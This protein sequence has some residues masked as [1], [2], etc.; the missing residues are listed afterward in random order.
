MTSADSLNRTGAEFQLRGDE[1]GARVH[2]LAALKLDPAFV[3]ALANLCVILSNRNQLASA[4]VLL[5]RITALAPNDGL[6]M[7][8]LGNILTRLERFDE[9]KSAFDRAVELRPDNPD[10][11]YNLLLWAHRTGDQ[12]A[13]LGY[14][15]RVLELG[16]DTAQVRNDRAHLYLALGDL[17]TALSLYE[18]RWE[19]LIHL[20]PWDLH[21]PEW[22]GFDL[23]GKHI[24]VHG[25]QGF[26][27][28]LMT[29]RFIPALLALGADVTFAV[30][31]N[32][33]RFFEFQNWNIDVVDI[34]KLEE[35]HAG[36]FDCHSPLYGVMRHLGVRRGDIDPRPFLKVPEIVGP[37]V[38]RGNVK[39]VGI[40]WVSGRRGNA[41]DWR[42]RV[43]DL[44]DWLQLADIPGIYLW[45]LCYDPEATKQIIDLG[46]EAIVEDRTSFLG[47][48]AD[49]AAFV[50]QLDL[51]ITVDTAIAHLA[52]GMGKATWMLSQFTPC[53]R[54][55][56][57]ANGTGWP[58]YD[59]MTI[60]PQATPGGWTNQ[61]RQCRI[62]L[63]MAGESGLERAA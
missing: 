49:T 43:S 36:Q 41:M 53:W 47:D 11:W 17:E 29:S 35:D 44:G 52:A 55:W 2:Y 60:I 59:S 45:S 56:D 21:L 32:M 1:E 5:R 23:N 20:E 16:S 4:A 58:W 15:E 22:N 38:F 46:A 13:A 50:D 12:V 30:P 3:P 54:W 39:N 61:L 37:P 7:S 40:C 33:V 6:Q 9:A 10:V 14:S 25:E 18:A 28:T 27:D 34:A 19:T 62:R 51:V 57:I 63:E 8:N 48:F 42:R 31:G 26:G 24:L